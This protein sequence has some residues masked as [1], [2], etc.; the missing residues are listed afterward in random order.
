MKMGQAKSSKWAGKLNLKPGALGPLN[1]VTVEEML[2]SSETVKRVSVL[3][4]LGNVKAKQ[5]MAA[6]KKRKPSKGK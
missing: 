6:Y 2:K 1:K 5:L 3:A 4:N